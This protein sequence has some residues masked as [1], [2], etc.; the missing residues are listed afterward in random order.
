MFFLCVATVSYHTIVTLHRLKLKKLKLYIPQQWFEI[1]EEARVSNRFEV[2]PVTSEL[3]YD[4]QSQLSRFFKKNPKNGK[5]CMRVRD[6]RVL[7]I[8]IQRD[9]K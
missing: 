9:W 7:S 2:V 6:V 8:M 4:F 5:H 1:I 3:I